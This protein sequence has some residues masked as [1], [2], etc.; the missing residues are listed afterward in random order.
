M[1]DPVLR[2]GLTWMDGGAVVVKSIVSWIRRSCLLES[3]DNA[4]MCPLTFM[5]LQHTSFLSHSRP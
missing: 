5:K 2:G 1:S 4:F 3:D